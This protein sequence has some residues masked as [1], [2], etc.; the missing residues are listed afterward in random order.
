MLEFLLVVKMIVSLDEQAALGPEDPRSLCHR[1]DESGLVSGENRASIHDGA[2]P[3]CRAFRL[4]VAKA[5]E[6]A[7]SHFKQ[8]V[9]ERKKRQHLSLDESMFNVMSR[10]FELGIVGPECGMEVPKNA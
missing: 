5:S 9:K 4:D 10:I 3:V 6:A 7:S 8:Q 1:K 2:V